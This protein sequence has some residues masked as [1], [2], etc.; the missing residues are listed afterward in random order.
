MVNRDECGLGSGRSNFEARHEEG[1]SLYDCWEIFIKRKKMLFGVFLAPFVIV[2]IVSLSLPRY[3][4]G[5]TEMTNLLLPA[6][7]IVRLIG[8]IDDTRKA[9]IFKNSPDAINSGSVSLPSQATDQINIIVE[10][11]TADAIQQAFQDIMDFMSNLPEIKQEIARMQENT[12]LKLG[13]LMEAQKENLIFLDQMKGM[14]KKRQLTVNC[15]NPSDLIEKDA[16]LS[17]QIKNLQREKVVVGKLAPPLITRQP[18]SSQVRMRII[19]A[20]LLSLFTS[21]F[22]IFFLE[23][24]E[25]M[26]AREKSGNRIS[27]K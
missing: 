17:L 13:H 12:D 22:V 21:I 6:P 9:E 11:K 15:I 23:Y 16:N 1:I 7:D 2:T 8:N 24:I 3:Y 5:E 27:E 18:S 25:R 4:R 14:M 10:A 20:G 19:I 26:K